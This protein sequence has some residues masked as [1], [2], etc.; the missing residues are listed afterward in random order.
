MTEDLGQ[1]RS[2]VAGLRSASLRSQHRFLFLF[3]CQNLTSEYPYFDADHSIGGAGFGEAVTDIGA[4]RMQ[5]NASFPVPFGPCDLGTS[6][7]ASALNLYTL[8]AH[9]H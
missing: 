6:Q 2:P 1:S 9:A 8:S 3:F 4:Q 7:T 5:R